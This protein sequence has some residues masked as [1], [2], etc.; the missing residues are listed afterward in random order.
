MGFTRTAPEEEINEGDNFVWQ[1][2]QWIKVDYAPPIEE[3]RPSWTEIRGK[4]NFLLSE[5]DWTQLSDSVSDKE[6]WA[7]YRA[8]LRNITEAFEKS[9]EVVFPKKPTDL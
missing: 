8:E 6:A 3:E 5:S 1:N 2:N 9:T 4:R 7:L